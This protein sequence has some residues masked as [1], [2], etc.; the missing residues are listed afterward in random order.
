MK[1]VENIFIR[2]RKLWKKYILL[3][4]YL[5]LGNNCMVVCLV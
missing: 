4:C 1:L 5:W 2:E 3:C